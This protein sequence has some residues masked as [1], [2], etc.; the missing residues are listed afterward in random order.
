MSD[1]QVSMALCAGNTEIDN[2]DCEFIKHLDEGKAVCVEGRSVW[3]WAGGGGGTPT[4][5]AGCST[6]GWAAPTLLGP[7]VLGDW[8]FQPC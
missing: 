2:R 3:L 7:V 8:A 4:C 1:S 5:A 6:Q